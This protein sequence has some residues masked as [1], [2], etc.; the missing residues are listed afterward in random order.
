MKALII[1]TDNQKI[2]SLHAVI[3]AAQA[4]APN[5]DILAIGQL[6]KTEDI[7]GVDHIWHHNHKD[8]N[9]SNPNTV[10]QIIKQYIQ[11]LIKLINFQKKKI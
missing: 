3:A 4:I 9:T 5:I 6:V 2:A 10:A 8:L 11:V 7:M 1:H